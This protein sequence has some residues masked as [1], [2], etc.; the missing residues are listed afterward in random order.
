ML[1][2]VMGMAWVAYA[3]VAVIGLVILKLFGVIE[4]W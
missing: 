1:L 2:T 4:F 3:I